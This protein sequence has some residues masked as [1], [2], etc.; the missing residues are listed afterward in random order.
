VICIIVHSNWNNKY[1][2]DI[3]DAQCKYED[4]LC[5]ISLSSIFPTML[6]VDKWAL[7]C[8][9]SYRIIEW[10]NAG[11]LKKCEFLYAILIGNKKA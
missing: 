9:W 1:C 11:T 3:S 5:R 10:Q 7:I 8:A 6:S 2:F 4:C